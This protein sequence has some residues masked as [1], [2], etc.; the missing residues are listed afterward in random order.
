MFEVHGKVELVALP[1]NKNTD[2]PRG[3][4]FVD[5]STEEELQKAVAGIDGMTYNNRKLRAMKSVPPE[6]RE[7]RGEST[8]FDQR[9]RRT[10]NNNRYEDTNAKKLY[11]GNIPFETSKEELQEFFAQYGTV[12]DVFVP[13]NVNTG[14]GRGFAFITMNEEESQAAIDTANGVEF[15]GRTL[16]VNRPLPQGE[17]T[18]ATGNRSGPPR[19]SRSKLYIGNLSFYTVAET[20]KEIFE[21]FGTVHDCYLPEDPSTGGTRGFGFVTMSREDALNAVAELDG[22]EVDGRTIRVNE[23]KPKGS[24]AQASEGDGSE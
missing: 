12:N 14:K 7:N 2:Q 17:R 18:Q 8:S 6:E 9:Q 20:L 5:M 23:A 10:G 11:V 4:A 24:F 21:E 13:Q 19:G 3:F 1:K 16:V 15:Q 22:C